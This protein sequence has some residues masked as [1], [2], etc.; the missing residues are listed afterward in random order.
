MSS[1]FALLAQA[2]AAAPAGSLPDAVGQFEL[3]MIREALVRAGGNRAH[4]ARLLG[5]PRRTLG[6]KLRAHG[7][8]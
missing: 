7:I 1:A 4:A 6:N 8:D 2:A 3:A 5:V